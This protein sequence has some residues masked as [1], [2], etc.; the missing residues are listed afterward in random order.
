MRYPF[1]THLRCAT[2]TIC[3]FAVLRRD[4]ALMVLYVLLH[5]ESKKTRHPTC[6]DNFAKYYAIFKNSFTARL[7][8]K[9]ATKRLLQ[10]PPHLKDIAALPSETVVFQL[11]PSSE[12]NTLLKCIVEFGQCFQFPSLSSAVY[13]VRLSSSFSNEILR[14]TFVNCNLWKSVNFSISALSSSL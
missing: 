1:C 2:E 10:I 7:S 5:S 14:I 6:V 11:L 12:A 9:F 4:L 3:W 13:Q 8:T